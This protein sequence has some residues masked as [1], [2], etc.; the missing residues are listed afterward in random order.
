MDVT[1]AEEFIGWQKVA[2]AAL[3]PQYDTVS[4]SFP[5]DVLQHVL[6]VVSSSPEAVGLNMK[7]LKGKVMPF[8][9]FK[10]EQAR[11]GAAE[12]ALGIRLPFDEKNLL[13][14]MSEYIKE[15]LALQEMTVA[16]AT[17]EQQ[18]TAGKNDL[19]PGNPSVLFQ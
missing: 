3:S 16:L 15:A 12:Q 8:A 17:Q 18:A 2:L 7:E 5:S 1:V 19:Y 11:T 14:E 9:K 6:A 13:E 10:M 4:N